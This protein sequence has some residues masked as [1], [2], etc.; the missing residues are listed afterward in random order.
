MT[1]AKAKT[2]LNELCRKAVHLSQ[3]NLGNGISRFR[4]AVR[5]GRKKRKKFAI[6]FL[7]QTP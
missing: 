1:L 7:V 3:G 2:N 5:M 4:D 6:P